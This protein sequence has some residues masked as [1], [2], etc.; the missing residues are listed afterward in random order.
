MNFRKLLLSACLCVLTACAGSV[1]IGGGPAIEIGAGPVRPLGY[2]SPIGLKEE[3][4]IGRSLAIRMF[5]EHGPVI[6]DKALRRYVALVGQAVAQAAERPGVEYRFAVLDSA[7]PFSIGLLGGYVFVS[8]GMLRL[9][10]DESQLAGV[11]GHAIAHI[12]G[13]HVL[14]TL[15]ANAQFPGF[16]ALVPGLAGFNP[17]PLQRLTD[18]AGDRV[19]ER[20]LDAALEY[21]AD[22][23]AAEYARRLGYHPGGLKH[24]LEKRMV[25][26][27]TNGPAFLK[28]PPQPEQRYRRL[29]AH[30][31]NHPKDFNLPRFA[32][33]Y[34]AATQGK[35]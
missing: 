14:K 5:R 3:Q 6:E 24:V 25:A 33:E 4:L 26:R 10:A 11:L 28:H 34:R 21:E 23:K 20:G 18:L 16:G 12:S 15:E 31:Q 1:G 19:F 7:V 22:R 9:V 30:L 29:L 2:A 27:P 17:A 32:K 13:R 8:R 35:L